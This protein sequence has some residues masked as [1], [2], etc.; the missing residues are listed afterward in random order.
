MPASSLSRWPRSGRISRVAVSS[1]VALLAAVGGTLATAPTASA[2]VGSSR[3]NI[4][5]ALPGS[6]WE[7]VAR[8]VNLRSGPGTGYSSYGQLAKGTDFTYHCT[9][10]TKDKKTLWYY[11]TVRQGAHKG[12]KGWINW[13]YAGLA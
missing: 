7:T 9:Y 1:A 3:C 2:A 10:Q 8:N 4:K 5:D 11:A 6:V 12:E 13:E